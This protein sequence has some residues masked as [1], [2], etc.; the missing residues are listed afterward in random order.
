MNNVLVPLFVR[1]NH[2][3]A[4]SVTVGLLAFNDH[5]K[6]FDYSFEKMKM[7]N[8]FLTLFYSAIS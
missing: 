8:S 2:L 7:A 1:L 6:F 4:D 3:T 5:S